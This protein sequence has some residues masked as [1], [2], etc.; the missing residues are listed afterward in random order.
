MSSRKEQKLQARARRLAHEAAVRA[1]ER[2]RRVLRT[3]LA[4]V[5][6]VVLVAAGVVLAAGRGPGTVGPPPPPLRL[7]SLASLGPL[8][9]PDPAAPN[10]PEGVPLPALPALAPAHTGAATGNIDG[11]Q[12][13]GREQ[14]LF[15]IHAHLTVYVDGAARGVPYG[16]GITDPH[17]I[18][19]PF[20]P[21][22]GSG[23]CFYWLHTH[24]AD[25][26]IHIESP[27][28][29]TYTLGDFFDVWGQTLGPTAVGRYRGRVTAIYNGKLFVGDPREVPLTAHAQIQLEIGTPLVAP[30]TISFPPGL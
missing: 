9:S 10:G 15:H 6:A 8:R 18:G 29:R 28:E 17:V 30:V 4:S 27:I 26:I 12:C 19:T 16:I 13:L 1:A 23:G 2:R 7:A 21:F 3:A 25:G 11:I 14:L 5:G 24:A 20:G 22:V